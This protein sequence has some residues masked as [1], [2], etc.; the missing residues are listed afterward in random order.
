MKRASAIISVLTITAVCIT[1]AFKPADITDSVISC[2]KTGNSKDLAKYLNANVELTILD[3]EDVYSKTQ[4]EIILRDFFTKHPPTG[5]N[6]LHQGGK[7]DSKYVIGNL[8]CGKEKFRVYFLIKTQGNVQS[9]HQL[10][11][12]TSND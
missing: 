3:K 5:Y 10:R 2:L 6:A 1:L 7:E 8:L 9:V 11:I 4:T 12:E